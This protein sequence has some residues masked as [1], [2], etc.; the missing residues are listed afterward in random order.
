MGM[1]LDLDIGVEAEFAQ[2]RN[3]AGQRRQWFAFEFR[4]EP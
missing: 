4:A 2:R 1:L 3:N